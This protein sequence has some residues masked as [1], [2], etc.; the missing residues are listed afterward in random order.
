[1]ADERDDEVLV[2]VDPEPLDD[3]APEDDVPDPE[4]DEA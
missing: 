3:D 4:D 2:P 1:M